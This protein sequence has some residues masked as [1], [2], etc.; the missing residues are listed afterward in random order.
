MRAQSWSVSP[1]DTSRPLSSLV[2]AGLTTITYSCVTGALNTAAK[3]RS[4]PTSTM[5]VTFFHSPVVIIIPSCVARE[6][7]GPVSLSPVGREL[8]R[9]SVSTNEHHSACD[10]VF[11]HVTHSQSV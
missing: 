5:N 6:S 3:R 8:S 9:S 11:V 7:P 2:T 10:R 1:A 4:R